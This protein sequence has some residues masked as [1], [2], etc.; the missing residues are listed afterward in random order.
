MTREEVWEAFGVYFVE[1]IM[2]QGWDEML[3]CLSPD[4][5]VGFFVEKSVFKWCSW[6][7]IG[8]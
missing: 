8:F 4:L 1:W 6:L 3:R 5:R 2:D 7:W